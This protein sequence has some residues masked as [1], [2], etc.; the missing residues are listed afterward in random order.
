MATMHQIEDK[1]LWNLV[2]EAAGAAT[3]PLL[4]DNPNY[5]FPSERVSA[6][7]MNVMKEHGFHNPPEGYRD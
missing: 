1:A 3:G 5:T 4:E 6:R 7:V 2:F